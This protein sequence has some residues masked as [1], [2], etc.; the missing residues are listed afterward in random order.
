[1]GKRVERVF[2]KNP[3][4]LNPVSPNKAAWFTDT[5]GILNTQMALYKGPAPQK[6]ILG[7]F[8]FDSPF[9]HCI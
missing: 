2:Q 4:T 5:D 8:F 1:M 3:L 9:L 7:C 6:I